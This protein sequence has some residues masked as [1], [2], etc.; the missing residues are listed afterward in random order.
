MRNKK[1]LLL[2]MMLLFVAV[3]FS[4]NGF[5]RGTIFD[6]ATGEYLPGVTVVI[7]GTTTGTITDLD[8]KFNLTLAP[9]VY[10]LRVSFISYETLKMSDVKVAAG[11]VTLFDNLR[12]RE[13][14]LKTLLSLCDILLRPSLL[15]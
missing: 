12:L 9:G 8:G 2:L 15:A 11:K 13:A 4:Q 1:N 10:S 3:G 14:S 6:D 7:E 5:I